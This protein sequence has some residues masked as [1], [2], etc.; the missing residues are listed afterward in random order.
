MAACRSRK[1]Y[2]RD[3]VLQVVVHDGENGKAAENDVEGHCE[4]QQTRAEELLENTFFKATD[5][6]LHEARLWLASISRRLSWRRTL[7]NPFYCEILRDT[8]YE[9][10]SFLVRLVKS[11]PEYCPPFCYYAENKKGEVISFTSK[12]LVVDFLVLLSRF[13][14]DKVAMYFQRTLATGSRKGHNV[15]VITSDEKDFAFIYKRRQGK[16]VISFYFGEWNSSGFPQNV[17]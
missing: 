6:F 1:F 3:E 12:R 8:P 17:E 7:R 15:S 4:R 10:F 13:S 11:S 2:T 16:L 5:V 14:A 9:M